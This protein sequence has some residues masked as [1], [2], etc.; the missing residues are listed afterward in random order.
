VTYNYQQIRS[1]P[2]EVLEIAEKYKAIQ[3]GYPE[4]GN[5]IIARKPHIA[6]YLGMKFH[7]IPII[8]SP[9]ELLDYCHS[10]HINYV[11]TSSVEVKL[12][13]TL[14]LL[15]EAKSTPEGFSLIVKTDVGD[16]VL[17]RVEGEGSK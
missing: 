17:Y 5:V 12:R 9:V 15:Q 1:G 7:P 2:T 8:G 10:Q 3:K 14:S 11:F 16:A 4:S 6:Y 13:P